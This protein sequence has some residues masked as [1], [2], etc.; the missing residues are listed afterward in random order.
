MQLLTTDQFTCTRPTAHAERCL[1]SEL[2]LMSVPPG[3]KF[4]VCWWWEL[5]QLVPEEIAQILCL[6]LVSAAR[7]FIF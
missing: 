3:A 6:H 2:G 7:N 5:T 1:V 4:I